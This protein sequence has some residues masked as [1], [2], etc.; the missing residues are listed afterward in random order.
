MESNGDDMQWNRPTE[1]RHENQA[2]YLTQNGYVNATFCNSWKKDE[3]LVQ[4]WDME[5]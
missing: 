2:E 5:G 4:R 1:A 3:D